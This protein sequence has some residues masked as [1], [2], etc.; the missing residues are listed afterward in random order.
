MGKYRNTVIVTE[1]DVVHR[2]EGKSFH[3]LFTVVKE[4]LLPSVRH[5]ILSG[6]DE[7]ADLS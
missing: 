5:G 1:S 4:D 2:A 6:A 3:H 7:Q